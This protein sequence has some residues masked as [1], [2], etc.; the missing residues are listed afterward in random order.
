MNEPYIDPEVEM[1]A[2]ALNDAWKLIGR[3]DMALEYLVSATMTATEK[4]A[5]ITKMRAEIK[6]AAAVVD[7]GVADLHLHRCQLRA[8]LE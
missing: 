2:K 4:R 5:L 1:Y 7:Q 8:R 6:R 3:L